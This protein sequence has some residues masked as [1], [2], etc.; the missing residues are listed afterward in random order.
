MSTMETQW[1]HAERVVTATN[2]EG[3]TKENSKLNIKLQ[4]K[5]SS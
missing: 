1:A 4:V 2:Q 3:P 5:F